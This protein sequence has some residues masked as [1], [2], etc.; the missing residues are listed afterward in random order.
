[1]AGKDKS[2]DEQKLYLTEQT[3]VRPK[4]YEMNQGTSYTAIKQTEEVL[5]KAGALQDAIFNS[6]NFS[7][8]ATDA[9][10]VIQIFNVG[11]ERMLG[12]SAA[13]VLDKITPA[14]FADPQE[15]IERATWLSNE[16]G[17]PITPGF[18]ALVFKASRGMEDIYELTKIRK[19]GSRF[20]AV[21]SV[22][23]LRNEQ[24]AIIGY[25]L[26]GTDN[27]ARKQI[28]AERQHLLAI[29]EETNQQLQQAN[30][31]LRE[32]E[33][34]LA[35][36]LKSIGDAVIAT[37]TEARVTILNPVAEKLTG[38]TQSDA[39][40]RPVA[41]IF[42]I[43][44]KETRLPATIPVMETLAHGTI[45]GLANHTVLIARDGG[46]CDIAD[47]CAP[48]RNRE[49]QVMGAVLVFRDVT[50]EYAI[51]QALKDST[52][53]VETILGSVV[54]G[55]ITLHAAGGIIET[56]NPAA[57]RM[58]GYTV[59]ELVGQKISLLI[60]ELDGEQHNVP[61]EYYS[62]SDAARAIGLGR[63]VV[64]RRKDGRL[65]PMEI[66]VSEMWLGSQRCF[67]G[68]LRDITTRKQSEEAL[69]KAGALQNAI[70]N[71][72]NFSSIATD[73]NGVIQIFNVGAERMLGYTADE[74]SNKIT[75]ADISD[76]QELITRA[77]ALSIEL[78]TPIN[79]GFEALVFKA[80]RGIEDIYELTYIRKDGSRFPAVVSVTA[81]R[82]EQDAII[83]YLLIGT[84]NTARKQ[85]EAEQEQLG[86][87]LRDHQFYTRSLFES[88]ID[89]LM[90]TDPA[91][92]I[93]DVNKQMEALTD[94]TRDELIGAPFKNYFTDPDR[95]EAS[96][97]RVLNDK[98]ITNYE[99]TARTRDGQETVVSLNATTFYDRDRKLQGVFAAARDVTERNL[100]DQVLEERTAELENAKTVAEEANLAKSDFLS[101]MSHEIRTPMNAIIGM[102]HLALK[103]KLTPRQRDY[104]KKIMGSSRH[105]L[106]IINDILDFSKIEVGKLTIEHTE[107][108]L[109]KVLD[110]VANLIAEKSA[111]KGLELVFDVDRNVPSNLIGD[112]LRLGQILINYSNNAITFTEQGEIDILIRL[113]EQTDEEV[114]LYCAVRD[115][116]IGLSEGQMERLFQRFSQADTTTTREFGG[117]GLGLAI[118]K[119]LAELMH[120]EV[121][122]ASEPGKGSTFW[123]TARL[124]KGLVQP[125]KLALS[126]DLQGKCVL[127][128]D[129]NDNARQVLGELLSTM[130]FKVD[131]AESGQAAINAVHRAELEEKP[132][133]IVFLDWQMPGMDGNQTAKLLRK[134]P[135]DHLPHLMMVTAFGREEVIKK[136]EQSGIEEVL[137]KPINPS[138][139]FDSVIRMLENCDNDRRT[140][141]DAPTETFEQ[142]ATITGSRILLVEDNKLN[143]EVATELL[144][145]AGFVVDLAKNG[146][147][148]MDRIM[149]VEYAL[150]L[151]DM[152]MPVMDGLTATREIR[153]DE[154]FDHLPIVAMTANAMQGD[155]ERCIAAGM[156]DHVAKPIEPENLW[157][158]L[159][160]WIKPLHSP[161]TVA[162]VPPQ[163][164]P[165]VILPAAIEGLDMAIGLNRVLG[166]KPLYLSMLRNF[167]TG[168]RAVAAEMLNAL[169]DDSWEIPERLAHTLK[170]VSGSIG[171][172]G[173]QQLAATLETSIRERRPRQEIEARL[174]ELN[175]PLT[176]LIAQLEQQL[177]QKLIDATVTVSPQ[178]LAAVCDKLKALLADDDAEAYDALDS[179]ADMLYAAFPDHYSRIDD[180][181]R[182]FDF[183]AALA[184]LEAATAASA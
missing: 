151:M 56:V 123:F 94:C 118:S 86:Q 4:E 10:G 6:A 183:K 169:E 97:K 175:K 114:T 136:A 91:G 177:P 21:V 113:K 168:Q 153:K 43:I 164:G 132:Y 147:I 41:E 53:R 170:G 115:T 7:S 76:P 139:L 103:T 155:R 50:G 95:A 64:G 14:D 79:P 116:G 146:R 40:G 30:L 68:I 158:A 59:A 82:D 46:E 57:E 173:L 160:Q 122:V 145:D 67:T 73:A 182:T 120:G 98:K 179:N 80:S 124:G 157:K 20:P 180:G 77:E 112:P 88:N 37:D 75:P 65:F 2:P 184:A 106:N 117:T 51:Q 9:N 69:L 35:V 27:T 1:M 141:P 71:S 101:N 3:V 87:R 23:A 134:L 137:I 102:S 165:E 54:D 83:G 26:I 74:V 143:Q 13:E 22:T 36:T 63:E 18:E 31:T 45:Q 128:V 12:Y 119:K 15:L 104:I 39:A 149:T 28:E 33:E 49:G 126:A 133:E 42:Q 129:D 99:L 29:Q 167:I 85:I 162:M 125:R 109:E 5:L 142:L 138:V 150:V 66:A 172:A 100:L 16:C 176:A 105:L 58:F 47:S 89:A 34:K 8:I 127:V 108:E 178:Q 55:I 70:F 25:L 90:T 72:A 144:R 135:Y 159:L 52:S 181:I 93:T 110:N 121:G 156:N 78:G 81:L 152:Q 44:N 92:I 19:D 62:A 131:Q 161:A 130:S 154:R 96:I 24:N 48:I 11:A 166:K 38:W 32:S 171:A 163:T 17:T 111:A 174:D 148:A 60:P 84:D 107:F 61:L 140:A